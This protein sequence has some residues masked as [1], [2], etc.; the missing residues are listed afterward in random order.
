MAM[1]VSYILFLALAAQTTAN[2][3]NT[4]VTLNMEQLRQE[5]DVLQEKLKA[6]NCWNQ[7]K[8]KRDLIQ[9]SSDG[10]QFEAQTELY[11][12]LMDLLIACRKEKLETTTK[13]S[14]PL[15]IECVNAVDLTQS[16]R[17]DHNGT[18][19][20]YKENTHHCDPREMVSA[21][22]PWFRIAGKAGNRLLDR[23]VPVK[24]CG[25]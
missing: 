6:E 5:T 11:N 13:T 2:I 24:S 25:T 23:C 15:P 22:R 9:K 14:V 8:N 7:Q 21:G 3:L 10:V 4:L 18:N 19:I 16:W 12:R 1:K 17:K 20:S